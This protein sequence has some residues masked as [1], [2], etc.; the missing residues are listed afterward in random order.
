MHDRTS[1]NNSLSYQERFFPRKMFLAKGYQAREIQESDSSFVASSSQRMSV[2]ATPNLEMILCLF[3]ADVSPKNI[4]LHMS[5]SRD[6]VFI[7]KLSSFLLVPI[8]LFR[9]VCFQFADH[10]SD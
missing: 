2:S 3:E 1:H 4:A 5:N 10:S 8:E 6:D 9:C 7:I